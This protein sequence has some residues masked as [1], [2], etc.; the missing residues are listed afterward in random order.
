M[1]RILDVYFKIEIVRLDQ[2]APSH[3]HLGWQQ[4]Y[5]K[6]IKNPTFD[7]RNADGVSDR[8][9]RFATFG[10]QLRIELRM[11]SKRPS[12]LHPFRRR[13][14]LLQQLDGRTRTCQLLFIQ[15]SYGRDVLL[16]PRSLGLR[17]W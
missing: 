13:I 10:F 7:A 14:V 11:R 17:V 16:Q 1:Q 8:R 4:D 3:N 9:D 6:Q 15:A 2:I 12:R 5:E